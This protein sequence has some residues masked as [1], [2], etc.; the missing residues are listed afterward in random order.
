[1][2]QAKAKLLGDPVGELGKLPVL[3]EMLR[4]QGH[5]CHVVTRTSAEML[6]V[7]V[8]VEH[9][10]FLY[11]QNPKPA[12]ERERWDSRKASKYPVEDGA[13]YFLGWYVAPTPTAAVLYT[14]AQQ[15]R[16]HTPVHGHVGQQR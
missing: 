5:V 9:T 10:E 16:R 11:E 1:M 12:E 14:H 6:E 7:F 8:E 3:A 4:A 13:T 2:A 15:R